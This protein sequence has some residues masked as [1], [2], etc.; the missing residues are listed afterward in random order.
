VRDHAIDEGIV[1]RVMDQ[2]TLGRGADL[3][4]KME[5]RRHRRGSG[6][7][8]IDAVHHDQGIA[9]AGLD[10]TRLQPLA[11][12]C[13]DALA[14]FDAAGEGD[15]LYLLIGDQGLCRLGTAGQ[16]RHQPGRQSRE[17]LHE[18]ERAKRGGRRRL[19]HDRIADRE[20]GRRG[21]GHQ[22]YREV[23]GQDMR[24]D[25]V[26]EILGILQRAWRRR[27]CEEPGIV[28]RHFREVAKD[29]ADIQQLANRFGVGLAHLAG[30]EFG[31]GASRVRFHR[32]SDAMQSSGPALRIEGGPF[33]LRNLSGRQRRTDMARFAQRHLSDH[34]QI[35][36]IDHILGL[37]AGNRA[38]AARDEDLR[39]ERIEAHRIM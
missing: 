22:D 17:M 39:G 28:P 23:E 33:S 11:A 32:V 1:H 14:G 16:A 13:G 25:A 12:G 35:G 30:H 38:I 19:D 6:D 10:H 37:R 9:A 21:E 31:G 3:A 27:A 15:D 18:F 34:A 26:G 36:W 7:V 29:R 2:D 4:R 5:R 20:R 24:A 8:R